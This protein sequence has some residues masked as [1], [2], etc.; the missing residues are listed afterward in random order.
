[1][2]YLYV[3]EIMNYRLKITNLEKNTDSTL[4]N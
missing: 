4:N 2:E 3:Y 1:M